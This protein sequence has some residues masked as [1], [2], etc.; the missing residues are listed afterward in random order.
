MLLRRA[1]VLGGGEL[2]EAMAEDLEATRDLSV[3]LSDA[4]DVSEFDVVLSAVAPQ[5]AAAVLR[6][7]I[8]AKC[9]IADAGARVEDA[10]PLDRLAA[11]KQVAACVGCGAWTWR[12]CSRA[13]ARRSS[14]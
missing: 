11:A 5:R 13:P 2:A 14:A 12:A 6:E 9:L 10:L 4:A 3:T 1:L 8:E 7:L